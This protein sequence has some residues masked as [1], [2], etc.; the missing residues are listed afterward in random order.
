L[1]TNQ[2]FESVINPP[3]ETSQGTNHD[4]SGTHTSPESTESDFGVDFLDVV[5]SGT[6]SLDTVE[7][8]DHSISGLRDQSAED[9]GNITRSEGN[10]ELSGL[11]VL[12]LRLG[13]DVSVEHFDGLFEGDE[14]HD[15]IGDLSSPEG[16]K[17]LIETIPTFVSSHLSKTFIEGGGESTSGGSLDSD[18]DGFP[19]AEETISNDFSGSGGKCPTDTLVFNGV[20]GS[21]NTSIDIL[22]DFIET[23]FTKTLKGI[24]D[25]SGSETKG[26]TSI[27]FSGLDGSESISHGLVLAGVNLHS[28]LDDIQRADSGVGKTTTQSTSDHALEII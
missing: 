4:N 18:L 3:L 27:S 16:S 2:G 13:E 22:E 9:T 5:R 28:A 15:S 20:F 26:K 10:G 17:T 19:R 12:V 24:S 1:E 8:G 21:N 25:Q 14:L 23:E 11:R 7:L 6:T